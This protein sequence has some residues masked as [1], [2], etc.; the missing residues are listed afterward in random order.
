MNFMLRLGS[1]LQIIHSINANI[2]KS[3]KHK[4]WNTSDPNIFVGDSTHMKFQKLRLLLKRQNVDLAEQ[5]MEV[6]VKRWWLSSHQEMRKVQPRKDPSWEDQNVAQEELRVQ[7]PG[8]SIAGRSKGQEDKV[9]SWPRICKAG[10]GVFSPLYFLPTPVLPSP[11]WAPVNLWRTQVLSGS[12]VSSRSV[13][14]SV[15]ITHRNLISFDM[16]RKE[17]TPIH[18]DILGRSL[19]SL[20][21][22][23]D[24]VRVGGLDCVIW[25]RVI[26]F[27]VPV[28]R[29]IP[30]ESKAE[31]SFYL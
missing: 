19:R 28:S 10:S 6:W 18:T 31:A 13:F 11:K 7:R 20:G 1:Y 26:T 5:V 30:D 23:K 17:Y 12:F 22:F 3:I 21:S 24:I 2:P 16:C 14:F 9:W 29:F 4:M 27:R 25:G 8:N 15:T